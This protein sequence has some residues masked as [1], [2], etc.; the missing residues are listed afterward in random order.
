MTRIVMLEIGGLGF[1]RSIRPDLKKLRGDISI[2][3]V[4]ELN[5]VLWLWLGSGVQHDKRRTAL[6]KADDISK[7]GYRAGETVFGQGLPIMVIDQDL[8]ESPETQ[9]NFAQLKA[10]FEGKLE[11]S[12]VVDRRGTL[13]YAE[14]QI[15]PSRP[16]PARRPSVAS[17]P[18]ITPHAPTVS[19]KAPPTT[20]APSGTKFVLEAA[21]VA[22]LRVHRELHIQYKESGDSEEISIESIDGLRH[23]LK[24]RHGKITFN[25]DSKTQK[26]LKDRVAMELKQLAG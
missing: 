12:S 3:I 25:W 4:D 17:E 19:E 18:T 8:L 20:P 14:T 7:E 10:L 23:T 9:G 16:T 21:L 24:R 6:A 1:V 2:L 26:S 15:E 5:S 11:I 22:I 13:I